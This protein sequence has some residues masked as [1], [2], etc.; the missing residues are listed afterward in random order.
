MTAFTND[1]SASSNGGIMKKAIILMM[2]SP[3]LMANNALALPSFESS[4]VMRAEDMV[5]SR[6]ELMGNRVFEPV[7]KRQTSDMESG[8]SSQATGVEAQE[9][10]N[11]K[12]IRLQEACPSHNAV[13]SHAQTVC[14]IRVGPQS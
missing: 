1:I 8:E 7:F 10:N 14:T 11:G 9:A 6:S 3:L 13:W 2:A 12:Q 5:D 4:E